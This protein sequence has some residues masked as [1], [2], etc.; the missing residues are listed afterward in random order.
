[1]TTASTRWRVFGVCGQ[2]S[3]AV[4]VGQR[5]KGRSDKMELG[6]AMDTY[7]LFIWQHELIESECDGTGTP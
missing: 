2:R 6:V 5:S 1:M 7:G 4:G 3:L